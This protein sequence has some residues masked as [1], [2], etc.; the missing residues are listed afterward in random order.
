MHLKN[1][2][3]SRKNYLF[4]TLNNDIKLW[5]IS[6]IKQCT[7][8]IEYC[9]LDVNQSKYLIWYFHKSSHGI[10]Y[11]F[12][13]SVVPDDGYIVIWETWDMLRIYTYYSVTIYIL[14]E[15]DCVWP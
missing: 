10:I 13:T 7:C 14:W 2:S 9:M 3:I 11:N 5:N 6:I 8:N 15:R 4:K 1:V 12:V